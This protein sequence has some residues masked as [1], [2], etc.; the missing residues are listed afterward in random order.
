MKY[1]FMYN[2]TEISEQTA[3]Y[4][5]AI[6]RT[7]SYAKAYYRCHFNRSYR[8]HM[9]SLRLRSMPAVEL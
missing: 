1:N 9:C 2:M 8:V 7:R 3:D 6:Y 4:Q 5:Q